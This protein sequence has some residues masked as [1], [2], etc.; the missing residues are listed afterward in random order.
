MLVQVGIALLQPPR[1][2]CTVAQ[3]MGTIGEKGRR[4]TL[5]KQWGNCLVVTEIES[6]GVDVLKEESVLCIML[7]S[8][9][10]HL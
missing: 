6:G 3:E 9:G 1:K 8:I 2:T 5:H 7:D 10:F 4:A